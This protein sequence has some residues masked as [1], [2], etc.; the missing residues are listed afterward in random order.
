MANNKDINRFNKDLKAFSLSAAGHVP[1][2]GKALGISD[3]VRKGKRLTR[4][5]PRA[6][7]AVQREA[8]NSIKRKF[9]KLR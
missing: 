9:K 4:S 7:R 6:L 2:L 5:A 8:K 3:T 1:G